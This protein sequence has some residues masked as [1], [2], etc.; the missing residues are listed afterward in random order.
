MEE[1]MTPEDRLDNMTS[2]LV[3]LVQNTEYSAKEVV[4]KVEGELEEELEQER[5]QKEKQQHK[6][7]GEE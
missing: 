3:G 1:P 4:E 5:I 2:S 6:P 7:I